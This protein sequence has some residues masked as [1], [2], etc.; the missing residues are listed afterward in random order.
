MPKIGIKGELLRRVDAIIEIARLLYKAGY[1][2]QP[3]Q[4]TLIDPL[5]NA[6]SIR[7]EYGAE[8]PKDENE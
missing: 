8:T 1:D 5:V 4:Q 3:I 2:S 7:I 6:I